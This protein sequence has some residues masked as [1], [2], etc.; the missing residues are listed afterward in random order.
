ML[1]RKNDRLRVG[2]GMIRDSL[3]ARSIISQTVGNAK[4]RKEAAKSEIYQ[5]A[6]PQWVWGDL[7]YPGKKETK[8]PSA[9]GTSEKIQS[10][11][12]KTR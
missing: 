7:K 9:E 1:R 12:G 8:M 4:K 6:F 11:A 10:I 3:R 2:G 5:G